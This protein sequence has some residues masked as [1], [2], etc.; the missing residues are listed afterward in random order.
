MVHISN[1]CSHND[2]NQLLVSFSSSTANET[3]NLVSDVSDEELSYDDNFIGQSKNVKQR[4]T[5]TGQGKGA[6]AT[7]TGNE[8]HKRSIA[9]LKA[10]EL[11]IKRLESVLEKR[12]E[13]LI[14]PD[15]SE[16]DIFFIDYHDDDISEV[17]YRKE[18]L[19]KILKSRVDGIY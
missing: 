9:S 17:L 12:G 6:S 5:A 18:S 1:S 2:C 10:K 19:I 3:I 11:E 4:A 7:S 16:F 14:V 15:D 8:Q 13:L